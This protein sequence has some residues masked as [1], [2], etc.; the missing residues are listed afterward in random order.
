MRGM[1]ALPTTRNTKGV[2][3]V[4]L[5][6]NSGMTSTVQVKTSTQFKRNG[7]PWWKLGSRDLD[8]VAESYVFV[9]FPRDQDGPLFHVVESGRMVRMVVAHWRE[10]NKRRAARGK[11]PRNDYN[12]GW[13]PSSRVRTLGAWDVI[14]RA[15]GG[16]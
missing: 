7:K 1:V 6:P 15:V 16:R 13:H 12:R 5:N 14:E 10:Y 2:D 4:V 8:P 9:L 3:I 11:E